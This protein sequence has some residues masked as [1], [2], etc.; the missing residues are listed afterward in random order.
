MKT[1]VAITDREVVGVFSSYEKALTVLNENIIGSPYTDSQDGNHL[2]TVTHGNGETV[3][4]R[5]D[6]F[7][8]V[9]QYIECWALDLGSEAI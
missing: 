5:T 4:I 7:Y 1:Y 8:S 6:P 2:T 9:T 3:F